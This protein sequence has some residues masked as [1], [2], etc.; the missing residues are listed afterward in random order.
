M[1]SEKA[2]SL[3]KDIL[4]KEEIDISK[5]FFENGGNSI[6]T[7]ELIG[8]LQDK[9]GVEVDPADF[10]SDPSFNNFEKLIE[11]ANK[12]ILN[13]NL[14]VLRKGKP[15]LNI[16]FVHGGS[17]EVGKFLKMIG[18]INPNY[19]IYAIKYDKNMMPRHPESIDIKKIGKLYIQYL[20]DAGVSKISCIVGW[21]IGGKIAYEMLLQKKKYDVPLVIL[22]AVAPNQSVKGIEG[23]AFD[24][25]NEKKFVKRILPFFNIKKST[26]K[27]TPSLWNEYADFIFNHKLVY[28]YMNMISPKY[29]QEIMKSSDDVDLFIRYFNLVRS[30]ERAHYTYTTEEKAWLNN[31]IY[32]NALKQS[33]TNFDY[34]G[35]FT[36]EFFLINFDSDHNGIIDEEVSRL[37]FDR[38]GMGIRKDWAVQND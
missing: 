35:K 38:L 24:F 37:I 15:D 36:N 20:E 25:E 28:K 12:V 31:I 5:N 2:I 22:N 4:K 26:I 21:C 16:V 7:I 13:E 18:S 10:Y 27:D 8:E 29:V 30:F 17:G 3:W 33:I 14:K 34:W 9:Y 19:T 11:M 23:E 6:Q 1:D 32:V